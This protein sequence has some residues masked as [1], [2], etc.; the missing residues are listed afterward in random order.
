[1]SLS[2]QQV[3]SLAAQ[4]VALINS[5]PRSPTKAMIAETIIAAQTALPATPPP[6]LVAWLE[7]L[8]THLDAIADVSEIEEEDAL[9][10]ATKE[11][12]ARPV[13]SVMDLAVLAAICVHWNSPI[14]I[15][16]PAYPEDVIC[17]GVGGCRGV[18]DDL[19]YDDLAL[20]HLVRGILDLAGLSSSFDADGRLLPATEKKFM[21]THG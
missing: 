6:A 21:A 11:F 1:M 12:W 18:G 2:N 19:G 10:V 14:D 3:S 16:D 7:I 15:G 13:Q 4:I 5:S 8:T 20:A 17:R 9:C